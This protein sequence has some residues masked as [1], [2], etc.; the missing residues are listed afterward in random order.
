M[1]AERAVHDS[2]PRGCGQ[3]GFDTPWWGRPVCRSGDDLWTT[4]GYTPSGCAQHVDE[5]QCCNY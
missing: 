3:H 4:C 2:P 5:P 1:T